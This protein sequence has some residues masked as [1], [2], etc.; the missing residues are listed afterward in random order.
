MIVI[1]KHVVRTEFD[2]YVYMANIYANR[3]YRMPRGQSQMDNPEKLENKTKKNKIKYTKIEFSL[4]YFC[5]DNDTYHVL[6]NWENKYNLNTTFFCRK[7]VI[8]T[9]MF[10]RVTTRSHYNIK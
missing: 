6:I 9:I 10:K 5:I 7:V 8:W 4:H 1:L 3:R 2:I